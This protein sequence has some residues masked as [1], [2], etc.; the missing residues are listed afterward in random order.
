MKKDKFPIFV[1]TRTFKLASFW[2]SGTGLPSR[3]HLAALTPKIRRKIFGVSRP[4]PN[5]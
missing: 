3:H 1:N 2:S 4:P 5:L